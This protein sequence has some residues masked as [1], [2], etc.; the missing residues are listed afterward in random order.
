MEG[1]GSQRRRP[2]RVRQ[3]RRA[4]PPARLWTHKLRGRRGEQPF[5]HSGGQGSECVKRAPWQITE[6]L[7]RIRTTARLTCSST[8]LRSRPK[9][10]RSSSLRSLCRLAGKPWGKQG[11]RD[12][13]EYADPPGG[14]RG[15]IQGAPH[16]RPIGRRRPRPR[17]HARAAIRVRRQLTTVS[18]G[19]GWHGDETT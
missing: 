6:T 11:T 8:R 19:D 18:G 10:R 1:K 14:G 2:L 16:T 17:E 5:D 4:V 12:D 3:L 9:T 13:T 15:F 7:S